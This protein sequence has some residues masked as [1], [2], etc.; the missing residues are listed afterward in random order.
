MFGGRMIH[1]GQRLSIVIRVS[2]I[3]SIFGSLHSE[4]T[5][6]FAYGT[7]VPIQIRSHCL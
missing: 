5:G 1:G 2:L 3:G 7:D 6:P 4:Y